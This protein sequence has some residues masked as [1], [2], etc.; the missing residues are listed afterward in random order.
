[1]TTAEG[2]QGCW[3]AWGGRVHPGWIEPPQSPVWGERQ[4]WGG[5]GTIQEEEVT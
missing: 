3:G 1:M 4:R 2:I 5:A